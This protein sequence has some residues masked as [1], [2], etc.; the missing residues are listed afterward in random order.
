MNLCE[1]V[2][3]LSAYQ[4]VAT[5]V[6]EGNNSTRDELAN[7]QQRSDSFLIQLRFWIVWLSSLY[8]DAVMLLCAVGLC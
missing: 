4:S 2:D 5:N 1:N 6:I 3:A 7:G 8:R